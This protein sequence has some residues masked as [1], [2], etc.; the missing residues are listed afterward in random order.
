MLSLGSIK[1]RDRKRSTVAAAET[2]AG[3]ASPSDMVGQVR[4]QTG[5]LI[6]CHQ[7][8]DV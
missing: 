8:E 7:A 2:Q 4:I 6:F 5:W 1:T 3:G